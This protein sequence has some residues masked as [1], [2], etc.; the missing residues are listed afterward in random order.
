[1]TTKILSTLLATVALSFGLVAGSMAQDKTTATPG[2]NKGEVKK[3]CTDVKGKDGKPVMDP[4]TNK[5]KQTCKDIKV[6]KKYE[7]TTVPGQK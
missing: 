6:R 3:V 1:M 7:A 2:E 5:P 4:K